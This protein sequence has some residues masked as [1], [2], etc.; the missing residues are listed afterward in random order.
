[1][2]KMES[3]KN[4]RCRSRTGSKA[5]K[6][7]SKAG[8]WKLRPTPIDACVQITPVSLPAGR[9]EC[10]RWGALFVIRPTQ[11]PGLAPTSERG[12]VK[13]G[14]KAYALRRFRE[15]KFA[16]K[17][18]CSPSVSYQRGCLIAWTLGWISPFLEILGEVAGAP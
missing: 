14:A 3:T 11:A 4:L 6:V 10:F 1:M 17:S 13:F 8:P 15:R 12:N 7:E 2:T 16:R 5:D 9:V 18:F